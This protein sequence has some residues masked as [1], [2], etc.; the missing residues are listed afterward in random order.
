M[1]EPLKMQISSLG[2]D[3][4]LGRLG[5]GRITRGTLKTKT[6]YTLIKRN[7]EQKTVRLAKL[8]VNEG[9]SRQTKD[10]AY[11]GDIVT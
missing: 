1:D 2:Y 8:F 3:D 10:E 9:L 4:Y 5:V 11:A 6:D 7:G